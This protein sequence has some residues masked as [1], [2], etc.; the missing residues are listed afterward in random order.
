MKKL[1]LLAVMAFGFSTASFAFEVNDITCEGIVSDDTISKTTS[2]GTSKDEVE[3][4]VI[5]E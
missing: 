3:S 5:D 4:T 2:T 1:V